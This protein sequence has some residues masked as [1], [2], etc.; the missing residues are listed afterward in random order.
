MDKVLFFKRAFLNKEGHHSNAALVCDVKSLI[1][2]EGY[3]DPFWSHYKISGCSNTVEL[4]MEFGNVEELDNT[5]YKL[6][7]IISVTKDFRDYAATL[8][9]DI[10]NFVEKRKI[11]DEVEKAKKKENP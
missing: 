4:A 9:K 5:L 2:E 11:E 6:D 8:R 3:R 10:E 7:T 1:E